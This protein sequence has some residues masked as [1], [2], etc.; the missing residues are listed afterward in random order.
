MAIKVKAT[1]PGFY[2]GKYRYEDDV[3]MVEHE[4]QLGSWM[5]RVSSDTPKSKKSKP[6]DETEEES[7]DVI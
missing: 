1:M 4:S 2:G 7:Q 3:F 5:E 6:K